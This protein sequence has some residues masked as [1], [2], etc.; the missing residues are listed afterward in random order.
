MAIKGRRATYEERVSA[1]ESI[2]NGVSPDTVA[3][4]LQVS[5]SSIFDWW[6]AYRIYGRDALRTKQTRGP[7]AKLSDEQM[8]QLYQL[9]SGNDPHQLS[10]DLALWTRGMVQ[11]L[12]WRQFG[13]RL[14]PGSTSNIIRKLGMSPKRPLYKAY[15]R[16]PERVAEWKEHVFP[17][18]QAHARKKGA[19]IFFVD[20]SPVLTNYA[21]IA[22]TSVNKK[23]A[24]RRAGK[25]RLIFMLAATSPRGKLLFETHNKR[26]R[27]DELLA[28]CEKLILDAQRPVFLILDNGQVHWAEIIKEYATESNGQLTLFFLPS[29]SPDLS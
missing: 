5:R 6:Q 18:I 9:I 11:E 13:I 10:F 4:L 17:E 1:C 27:E 19:L 7:E 16:D 23:P 8:S 20:E 3:K 26:I 28:F 29:Y 2:E 14:S 25:T 12:I 22:Q 21:E 24:V 15:E